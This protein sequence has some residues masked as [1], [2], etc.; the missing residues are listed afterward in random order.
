MRDEITDSESALLDERNESDEDLQRERTLVDVTVNEIQHDIQIPPALRRSIR[1]L[2]ARLRQHR[3][4]VNHARSAA[5]RMTDAALQ[6]GQEDTSERSR[7][8]RSILVELDVIATSVHA[9]RMRSVD[10]PAER[11][12][13]DLAAT[14]E[15]AA[16]RVLECATEMLTAVP[17]RSIASANLAQETADRASAMQRPC[18]VHDNDR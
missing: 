18:L 8:L 3:H 12:V 17:R 9:I 2:R 10:L 14:I 1:E 7:G 5:R 16:E 6:E 4:D 11:D 13:C 15:I